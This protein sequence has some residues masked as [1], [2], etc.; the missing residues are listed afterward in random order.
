WTINIAVG[1]LQAGSKPANQSTGIPFHPLPR[2]S[3]REHRY[4]VY[5]RRH[6]PTSSAEL[7]AR[8]FFPRVS[9]MAASR[10]VSPYSLDKLRGLWVHLF[11]ARRRTLQT[12]RLRT[13]ST[14]F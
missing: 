1:H 4:A 7:P 6:T 5:S 12:E 9:H 8:R 2:P 10:T 11:S 13:T 14:L 3:L